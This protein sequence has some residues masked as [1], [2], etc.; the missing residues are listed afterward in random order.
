MGFSSLTG[1]RVG[2]GMFQHP[3]Y[4]TSSTRWYYVNDAKIP[5]FYY[6]PASIYDKNI[7]L[8]KG[9]S[10][11]LKYRVWI[12]G[13]TSEKLLESKYRQYLGN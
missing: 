11:T 4:T 12:L 9:E 2:I 6:S 10:L 8:L 3:E 1:E 7:K 5:F 13:Q